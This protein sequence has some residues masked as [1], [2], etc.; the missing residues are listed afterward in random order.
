MLHAPGRNEN[1]RFNE[2]QT[3][4]DHLNNYLNNYYKITCIQIYTP[5]HSAF[6]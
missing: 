3:L 4:M 1:Y 6:I 2:E 5:N